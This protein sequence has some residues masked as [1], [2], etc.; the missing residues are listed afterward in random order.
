MTP[1]KSKIKEKTPE[2]IL[3]DGEDKLPIHTPTQNGQ[4]MQTQWLFFKIETNSSDYPW[5]I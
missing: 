5:F 2:N 4:L 3:D 1:Q